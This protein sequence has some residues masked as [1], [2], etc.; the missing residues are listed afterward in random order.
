MD[1]LL[2]I[3]ALLFSVVGIIGGILPGLPGSILS[4]G[5]LWVAYAASTSEI[6]L[7]TLAVWGAVT[8]AVM[9]ADY[10][11]PAWMT[12]KFGG[13]RAGAVGATVG[14]FAGC[15][16]FPPIGILL[17]PFA[18]AVI[19]ELLNDGRDKAHAFRV[20]VGSFLSFIVGTGL[21]L[22]TSIWMTAIVVA[23]AV[24]LIK[25]WF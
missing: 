16:I 20:G 13:S 6:S 14:V 10:V 21:K 23:D 19:G 2:V 25:S 22:I 24:P 12:R 5:A 8:V 11:L 17:G 9:I 15:F 4:Y 18:G 7:T 3:I 1:I